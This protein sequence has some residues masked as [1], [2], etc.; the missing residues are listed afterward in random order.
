M[1]PTIIVTGASRGLGEALSQSAANLGANV[2]LNSRSILDLDR[3]VREIEDNGGKAVAVQGDVSLVQDCQRIV[4]KTVESY[5]RIDALVNNAATVEP[6]ALIASTDPAEWERSWAVNVFG[7]MVLTQ[8]A[9]PYLRESNGRVINISS[10]AAERAI[11]GAAGYCVTKGALNQFNRVLAAEE[12]SI[13][14]IAVRP[15]VVDTQMQ[16]AIRT[17]GQ[18][19]MPEDVHRSFVRYHQ[20]GELLPPDV[21]GR[22]LAILAL[23]APNDWSGEFLSWDEDRVQELVR[24]IGNGLNL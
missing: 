4:E 23:H 7:P 2:V 9:L 12:D 20:N 8:A 15:G 16:T 21:P 10:G 22:T 6:I 3:L 24:R 17:E 1:V 11:A 18:A 13:T 19:G 14:A 5:G